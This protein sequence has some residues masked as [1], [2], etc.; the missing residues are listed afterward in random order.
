M[1]LPFYPKLEQLPT[2]THRQTNPRYF[3][4]IDYKCSCCSLVS[5]VY[6]DHIVEREV[7]LF[8]RDVTAVLHLN[9]L[10]PDPA[11]DVEL[12]LLDPGGGLD[13]DLDGAGQSLPSFIQSVLVVKMNKYIVNS[14]KVALHRE[15]CWSQQLAGK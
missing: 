11:L 14:V 4:F 7:N 8:V 9:P 10:D 12:H 13:E 3:G 5:R 2:F 6:E 1:N 15:V